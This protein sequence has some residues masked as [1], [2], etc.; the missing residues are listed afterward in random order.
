[1]GRMTLQLSSIRQNMTA[2]ANLA[3]IRF[4]GF[5][6][7]ARPRICLDRIHH[8]VW[9]RAPLG[10]SAIASS[11]SAQDFQPGTNPRFV[12]GNLAYNGVA[13]GMP[14]RHA[15]NLRSH[16]GGPHPAGST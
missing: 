5:I 7:A 1:M 13:A 16:E 10:G 15:M 3:P 6:P 14:V 11:S 4:S 12:L 9:T 2:R 8:A